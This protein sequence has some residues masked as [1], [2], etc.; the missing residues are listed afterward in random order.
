MNKNKEKEIAF[1]I[2]KEDLQFFATES[3]GRRLTTIELR[4]AKKILE[5]SFMH[6]ADVTFSI[7]INEALDS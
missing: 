6:D 4:R 5:Y 1:V 2:F 3:I 7:A